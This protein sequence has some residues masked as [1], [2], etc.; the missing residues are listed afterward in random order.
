MNAAG[1]LPTGRRAFR[2]AALAV[3]ALALAAA[4]AGAG[5]A[6]ASGHSPAAA[7]HVLAD[8][9]VIHSES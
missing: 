8:D 2:A 3:A 9:G 7:R 1:S 6:A 5:A 4:A